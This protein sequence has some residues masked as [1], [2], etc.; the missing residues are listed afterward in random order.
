LRPSPVRS[1]SSQPQRTCPRG[2]RRFTRAGASPTTWSRILPAPLRTLS[3]ILRDRN[4]SF[5]A[6]RAVQKRSRLRRRGPRHLR[7]EGPG[8]AGAAS[9]GSPGSPERGA[10]GG[11]EP[12]P[13]PAVERLPY[14]S[15]R[16]GL[17]GPRP[18]LFGEENRCFVGGGVTPEGAASSYPAVASRRCPYC[19]PGRSWS[20]WSF[21]RGNPAWQRVGATR[22]IPSGFG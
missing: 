21:F 2:C 13:Y 9:A 7:G 8:R 1:S 22:L 16:R 4:F 12:G 11:R 10:A 15:C 20:G 3:C 17:F 6:H 5:C 14:G 19:S 18:Q